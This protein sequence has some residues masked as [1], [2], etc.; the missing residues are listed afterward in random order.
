[1]ATGKGAVV[2]RQL[3]KSRG[4]SETKRPG[5]A[6]RASC[7]AFRA[8]SGGTWRTRHDKVAHHNHDGNSSGGSIGA[9]RFEIFD[10]RQSLP[11]IK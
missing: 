5:T 6:G 1:M 9:S 4:E 8:G 7:R 10:H 3:A 2:L 11:R